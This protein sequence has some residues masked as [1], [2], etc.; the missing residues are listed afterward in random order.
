M[1]QELLPYIDTKTRAL[2]DYQ[3]R[4]AFGRKCL[5]NTA[6]AGKFSSDRSIG[7]YASEIWHIE[8]L[9]CEDSVKLN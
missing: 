6:S 3:D 5:M 2:Y 7:Q 9:E 1:L 8:P 4:L